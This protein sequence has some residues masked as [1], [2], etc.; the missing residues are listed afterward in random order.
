MHFSKPPLKPIQKR[1]LDDYKKNLF[2]KKNNNYGSPFYHLHGPITKLKVK[3][4]RNRVSSLSCCLAF[5]HD[6]CKDIE[7]KI[8]KD[9][10]GENQC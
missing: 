1:F 8:C 9:I 3:A 10:E 6:I 4:Q 7:T 2:L 5:C